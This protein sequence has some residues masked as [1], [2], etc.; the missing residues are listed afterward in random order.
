MFAKTTRFLV[1]DDR[2]EIRKIFRQDMEHLGFS[3]ITASCNGYEA[4]QT[5][6]LQH[7][8]NR[9]IEVVVSDWNMPLMNGYDLLCAMKN[10]DVFCHTPFILMSA[11]IEPEQLLTVLKAGASSYLTKP[12]NSQQLASKLKAVWQK[13]AERSAL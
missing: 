3:D 1:V 4:L 5:L 12:F 11:E 7:D 6:T 10:S 9:P 2:P 13:M 8:L